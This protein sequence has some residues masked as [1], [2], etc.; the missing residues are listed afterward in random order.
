MRFILALLCLLLLPATVDAFGGCLIGRIQENARNRAIVDMLGQRIYSIQPT[1]PQ[2]PQPIYNIIGNLP[3]QP[4][5][6]QFP[7]QPGSG[8]FPGQL[9]IGGSSSGFY[10]QIE[11]QQVLIFA[12]DQW[13]RVTPQ[14]RY[15][16]VR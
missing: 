9:P 13:G 2:I 10:P 14:Y 7:I 16:P 3:I 8:Q 5:S 11:W 12:A 1:Q 4:G 15:I 6:G